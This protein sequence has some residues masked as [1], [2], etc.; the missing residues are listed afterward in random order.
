MKK[1]INSF[2]R[3]GRHFEIIDDDGKLYCCLVEKEGDSLNHP[4]F[5]CY[6]EYEG[7]DLYE[8]PGVR[9]L[10]EISKMEV[11]LHDVLYQKFL[12]ATDFLRLVGAL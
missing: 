4:K 6:A 9:W 12:A 5:I 10:M 8:T 2:E 11:Q 7:V 1:L 3:D